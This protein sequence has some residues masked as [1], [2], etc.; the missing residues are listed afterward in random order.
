MRIPAGVRRVFRLPISRERI[1]RDLDD[2]VRFHVEMRT[3]RLRE[4]GYPAEEARVEAL[5]RFG[6]VD[7]LRNYC[8]SMEVAHMHRAHFRERLESVAHDLRFAVRT[9]RKAPGFAFI[10]T[11]T[12]A[13]GVGATTAIFSV[14]NGV[15]LRPLPF[16]HPEQ[17]VQLWGLDAKGRELSFADPTFDAVATD[18]RSFSAVAE[19]GRRGMSIVNDGEA[20]QIRAA[21]V[22]RQFFD[23]LQTKTAIGR[24]FVPEEQQLGA[25][26]AIVISHRL[27][28]R[29]FGSSP[30]A[31]GATLT[32]DRK[33]LTVIGV[34]R[35]GQEFP[36]GT[37]VWYPREIYEKNTSYTAHNWQVIGRVKN[38]VPIEQAKRD[39]SM[40]LQRLHSAIGE[41]TITLD[42]TAIGLREQIVGD[43]KPLLLLLL[44]ASG[45][46]L[47]IAC[48]NVAN[49]LI[50]RM[51]VR[52]NEIAVRLAIGAGRGRLAQQLLIEASLLSAVGCI[53]GLL[54][55][56]AGMRVLLALRPESIPRVD[57]LHV[58]WAVLA[59]AIVVSAG[60]A[61]ALG[62]LAAWRGAR[63]DLRAALA[64]S[65]R[66]QSGG[67]ASYRLRGSLVVV[68]LA[69][70]V[71]LLIGAGLLARSFVRLMSIDT[72]FRTRGIVVANLAF[73]AGD[74][75]GR[76][77]RRTQY[78]D[79]VVERARAIPGVSAVGVS[80]SEPFSG[81]SSNGTFAVLAGPNVKL[82]MQDFEPLFRDKA[83]TGY[84]TYR[85]ANGEYFRAM[86]I[87]I[88]AG[89][90][91]DETDREGGAEV[92]IVSAALA[93]SQWPNES[94][95]GKV[96]EFGNID[97][98]LT[99]LTIVGV[100]GDVREEELA[101]Q[102]QPA[103]YVN[104]RQRP[105]VSSDLSIIVTTNAELP[106][107]A[108]ARSAFRLIRADVPT[109][110]TTVEEIVAS[111]VASQRFMLL[112]VGVFGTVA[113]L[114]ATLG[115]YSVI[116]YLVAQRGREISIRVA[117]GAHASDIVRLVIRQGVVLALIGAAVG[118]IAALATTRVLKALLYSVSTTDPIAFGGVLVM[119]CVVALVASYLPA[120]RASRAEPMDVLR[121]A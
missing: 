104:V 90:L 69:M 85:Q 66:T 5:R 117:L 115:V 1:A 39:L 38:G 64:Q 107:M 19:Y 51:A 111:S 59:F 37:D 98:D 121:G 79:Q 54:L 31:I 24:L 92:A 47:L 29:K 100:V 58:D 65:Q 94:A 118:A 33:P 40:T 23:V 11:L 60:T 62:L 6:D 44:G 46:L 56:V 93:K 34:L 3:K 120:R 32:S 57:E 10:A 110:F 106:V 27:W 83:H 119:L 74:G 109:R 14:V 81:G 22:S 52:E 13:L 78:I 105:V 71:V 77:G 30:S 53:G 55:A 7:D 114:L 95:L 73:D 67:G 84:A 97:G 43:I 102:P 99:P 75:E 25:P 50:A 63:G 101:A 96:I 8:V 89:R 17:I 80:N 28:Q 91:F 21:L 87:P 72:G 4:K 15:V 70:T 113:L 48:A 116:S 9:F 26:T 88:V 41:N 61:I 12:L 82:T 112:L 18:T 86:N 35:D 36:A 20:E 2:E 45:V 103:I 42:G 68:Q 76:L 16:D 49:L 108:A